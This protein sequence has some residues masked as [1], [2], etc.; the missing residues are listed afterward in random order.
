[1]TKRDRWTEDDARNLPSEEPDAFERKSGKLFDSGQDLFLNALAKALSAFANSGGGSIIIGVRDDGTFDGLTP[2][3]GRATIRDWIEMKVPTLLEYP[4]SDFRVHTVERGDSSGVPAGRV[5]VVIDVGDS[6]VAPHQSKRDKIYYRREGGRSVPAPHFYLELLRQRLTN[7]RLEI[8]LKEIK[9]FHAYEI[10]DQEGILVK[11][12]LGFLV[13]NIGR[14][15]ANNWQINIRTLSW[16]SALDFKRAEDIMFSGFPEPKV[17]KSV[18]TTI[19]FGS[20]A[21]LPGCSYLE[22]REVGLHLRPTLRTFD[23]LVRELDAL[24]LPISIGCQVAT[25]TSP[26]ELVSVK[27]SPAYDA[28]TIK[29][30]IAQSCPE[31]LAATPSQDGVAPNYPAKSGESEA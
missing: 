12:K 23:E 22:H 8:E 1:M 9:P 16:D 11:L 26:G 4:L 21:I 10:A 17:R 18:E 31:F 3:V 2:Y 29:A 15:S 14:V 20:R 5:V 28:A 24:I 13:Q 30:A 7:P 25:E 6:A 19:P 27:L